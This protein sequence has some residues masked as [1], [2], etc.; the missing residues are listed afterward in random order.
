MCSALIRP[1]R[2][3]EAVAFAAWKYEPPFDF[4]DGDAEHLD[5]YLSIDDEGYGCYAVVDIATDEVIGFCGFG[6]TARVTGQEPVEGTVD[7]GGGVRPDLI[8]E[9]I[10]TRLLPMILDFAREQFAPEHF[11]TAV[12]TFNERS[13]RLCL[14]A[15]FEVVRRFE[16]PG[17]EF[18]ELTRRA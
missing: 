15:G 3:D 1:F 9:G 5:E 2:H 10:A 18:Q 8:S 16:G 14:S 4:Y 12:A 6:Q 17:R 7:V 11:R 13:T